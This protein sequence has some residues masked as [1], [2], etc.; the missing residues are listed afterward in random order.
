MSRRSEAEP[1]AGAG[2]GKVGSTRALSDRACQGRDRTLIYFG[3]AAAARGPGTALARPACPGPER[4]TR[5]EGGRT[6]TPL[7]PGAT[8]GKPLHF[9]SSP[10][11]GRSTHGDLSRAKAPAG[12]WWVT[13]GCRRAASRIDTPGTE[14]GASRVARSDPQFSRTS[15]VILESVSVHIR[16]RWRRASLRN[17]GSQEWP[18]R[19]PSSGPSTPVRQRYSH[20][21][22]R[23]LQVPP[24]RRRAQS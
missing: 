4:A 2:Q 10:T 14:H 11:P 1:Q 7:G 9:P 22:P 18:R 17:R 21:V 23:C 19:E 8:A 12:R 3:F 16:N 15:P 20:V 13:A 6:P 24:M 5:A